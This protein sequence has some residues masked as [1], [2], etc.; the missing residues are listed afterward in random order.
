MIDNCDARKHG[1]ITL[2]SVEHVGVVSSVEAHLNEDNSLHTGRPGDGK[3]E[4]G[5]ETGRCCRGSAVM[6]VIGKVDVGRFPDVDVR[7]DVIGSHR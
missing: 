6:R 4:F 2:H 7:V 1:R 3:Q 5:G